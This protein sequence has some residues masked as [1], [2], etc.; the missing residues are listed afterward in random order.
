MLKHLLNLNKKLRLAL[1]S[2]RMTP[3]VVQYLAVALHYV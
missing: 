3:S 2:V 1:D